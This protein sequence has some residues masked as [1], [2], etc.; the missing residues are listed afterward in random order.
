MG[1]TRGDL[2]VLVETP[3][4]D[5][6]IVEGGV[7]GEGGEAVDRI[8]DA[9]DLD[10]GAGRLGDGEDFRGDFGDGED[11]DAAVALVF[12]LYG[13]GVAAVLRGGEL[14]V[15]E[16]GVEGF[17]EGDDG[18]TGPGFR[19]GWVAVPEGEGDGVVV[20]VPDQFRAGL[21]AAVRGGGRGRV[22]EGEFVV[23]VLDCVGD[24]ADGAPAD[25]FAV[26]DNAFEGVDATF[27]SAGEFEAADLA[28]GWGQYSG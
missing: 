21:D 10:V 23:E 24:V 27:F 15:A 12:D 22:E 3:R 7:G 28:E 16:E 9:D 14:F 26:V 20:E 19:G 17:G 8:G 25:E 13:G 4:P 1:G 6:E 11:E 5:Q 18:E 2:G